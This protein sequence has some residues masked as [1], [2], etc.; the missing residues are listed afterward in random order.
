MS[1]DIETLKARKSQMDAARLEF[2]AIWKPEHLNGMQKP[3]AVRVEKLA[4]IFFL[5]GKGLHIQ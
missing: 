2:A 1:Q 3:Y 4:W 5:H